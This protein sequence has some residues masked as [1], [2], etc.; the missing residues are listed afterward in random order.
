MSYAE[1]MA[2]QAAGQ[3]AGDAIADEASKA[4][5]WYFAHEVPPP[6]VDEHP[7]KAAEGDGNADDLLPAPEG[8]DAMLVPERGGETPAAPAQDDMDPAL[9]I[10]PTTPP[11][12]EVKT[13]VTVDDEAE[14]LLP[15][16]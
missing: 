15:R 3:G 10:D 11:D 8:G 5:S 9:G 2:L 14:T 12:A 7:A 13:E 4:I 1:L 6:G 16:G